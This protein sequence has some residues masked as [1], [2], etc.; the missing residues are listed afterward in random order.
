[1]AADMGPRKRESKKRKQNTGIEEEQA[2]GTRHQEQ[3]PETFQGI[4]SA[5]RLLPRK[6][7]IS[8][9]CFII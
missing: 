7:M 6:K 3:A 2:P 5:Q 4:T 8:K 1:M 9:C